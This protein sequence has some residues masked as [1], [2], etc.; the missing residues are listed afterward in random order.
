MREVQRW[1]LEQEVFV[2]YYAI[3][4]INYDS[5]TEIMARKFNTKRRT[6]K[7]IVHRVKCLRL[8]GILPRDARGKFRLLNGQDWMVKH[9]DRWIL[10]TLGKENLDILLDHDGKTAAIIENVTALKNL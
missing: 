1:N 5:I 9:T 7:Q 4:N 2:A 3:R 6:H 8:L 10:R